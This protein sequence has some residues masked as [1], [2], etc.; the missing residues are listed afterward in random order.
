M[1]GIPSAAGLELGLFALFFGRDNPE[2]TRRFQ[3]KRTKRPDPDPDSSLCEELSEFRQN[4]ERPLGS[5][6]RTNFA[7]GRPVRSN[8]TLK[9]PTFGLASYIPPFVTTTNYPSYTHYYYQYSVLTVYSS[10]CTPVLFIS[11]LINPFPTLPPLPNKQTPCCLILFKSPQNLK[12]EKN[13]YT[14][15][16]L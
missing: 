4:P 11:K 9:V 7:E 13:Y 5:L 6:I 12:K 16:V 15:S 8:T 14:P 3:F 2:G 10:C 1:T